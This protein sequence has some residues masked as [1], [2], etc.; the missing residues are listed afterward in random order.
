A[1]NMIRLSGFTE[2]DISIA[3]TGIRNGE[4][5]HESLF[6]DTE[7]ISKTKHEKILMSYMI[8]DYESFIIDINSLIEY[9][10]DFDLDN[11]NSTI[12]KLVPDYRKKLLVNI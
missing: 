9:T 10:K 11:I 5:I 2:K 12:I 6:M 8:I 4:K 1:N 7:N 3:Y